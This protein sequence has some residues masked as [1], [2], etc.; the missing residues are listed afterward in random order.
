MERARRQKNVDYKEPLASAR[1][2]SR[3][4]TVYINLMSVNKL[5]SFLVSSFRF[6]RYNILATRMGSEDKFLS[7]MTMFIEENRRREE[8][9]KKRDD[10]LLQL[11]EK[12]SLRS[13]TFRQ[14]E[15][16]ITEMI[17]KTQTFSHDP[18]CGGTFI[19]WIE[20]FKTQWQ[21]MVYDWY[22]WSLLR[23]CG[24]TSDH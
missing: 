10:V 23:G 8:E 22:T 17:S 19:K 16:L 11:L 12:V 18:E 7:M 6:E 13:S 24:P 21:H 5:V 3:L 20:R 4:V 14:S 2:L 9:N 1:I 15:E